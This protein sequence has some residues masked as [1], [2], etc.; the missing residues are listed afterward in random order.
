MAP[1]GGGGVQFGAKAGGGGS[2]GERGFTFGGENAP[3]HGVQQAHQLGGRPVGLAPHDP[4]M[5]GRHMIY[6]AHP[7]GYHR[8]GGRVAP[9]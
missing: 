7:G 4:R 5:R 3:T 6:T 9:V 1:R 8:G 2:G